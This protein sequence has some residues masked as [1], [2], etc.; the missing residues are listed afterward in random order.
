MFSPGCCRPPSRITQQPNSIDP[1]SPRAFGPIF[2]LRRVKLDC[3]THWGCPVR[4]W[5]G[6]FGVVSLQMDEK[7][8]MHCQMGSP[9]R[10]SFT[11][12]TTSHTM[13]LYRTTRQRS[14][15]LSREPILQYLEKS[16][17]FHLCLSDNCVSNSAPAPF[18]KC[19]GGKRKSVPLRTYPVRLNNDWVHC[20][21]RQPALRCC[22][23]IRLR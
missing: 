18:L 4:R 13:V 3:G 23:Q 2:S 19:E 16:R 8:K 6:G 9:V 11:T 14:R 22:M 20:L 17:V 21:F 1:V 10:N 12:P 7:A 5:P 15:K